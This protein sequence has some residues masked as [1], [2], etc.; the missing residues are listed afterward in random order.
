MAY[1]AVVVVVVIVAVPLAV[2]AVVMNTRRFTLVEFWLL[3]LVL[4]AALTGAFR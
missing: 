2:Y 4:L 3:L 1:N